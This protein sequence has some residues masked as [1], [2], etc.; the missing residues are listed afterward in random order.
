MKSK[1][2]LFIMAFN[3]IS[4]LFSSKSMAATYSLTN[5]AGTWYITMGMA[6]IDEDSYRDDYVEEYMLVYLPL[7]VSSTGAVSSG[8]TGYG[9][10]DKDAPT[11]YSATV[12]ATG[13][14]LKISSSGIVSGSIKIRYSN[15]DGTGSITAYIKHGVMN[16]SKNM[17]SGL[18]MEP[19]D[20]AF[21]QFTATKR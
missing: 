16:T 9:Y 4:G 8:G 18:L 2:F 3:L 6:C 12:T 10:V 11:A 1:I 13:G 20:P 19:S 21:G 7:K 5:L 17:I 15:D 14:T